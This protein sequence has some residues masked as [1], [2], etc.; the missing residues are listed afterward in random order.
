[1]DSRHD[2]HSDALGGGEGGNEKA[3]I[4]LSHLLGISAS[5]IRFTKI[6]HGIPG[7]FS[8]PWVGRGR[9]RRGS[10]PGGTGVRWRKQNADP[11][12]LPRAGEAPPSACPAPG[13]PPSG[14]RS[15]RRGE[16][17]G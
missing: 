15:G 4:C 3:G 10:S 13:E 16:E 2:W 6:Y 7:V 5:N 8:Q 9:T 11:G 1:M 17:Y 14:R 12:F